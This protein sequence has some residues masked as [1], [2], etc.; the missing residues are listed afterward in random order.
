MKALTDRVSSSG[1]GTAWGDDSFME[2]SPDP[3]FM[4]W[5]PATKKAGRSWKTSRQVEF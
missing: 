2:D 3:S 4:M 1:M 5:H